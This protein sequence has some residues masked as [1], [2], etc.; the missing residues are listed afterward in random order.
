MEKQSHSPGIHLAESH[1]LRLILNCGASV[2][3][4]CV[5]ASQLR[6]ARGSASALYTTALHITLECLPVFTKQNKVALQCPVQTL[7][8]KSPGPGRSC[9]T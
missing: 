2:V 5:P 1:L 4:L 9:P 7:L 8:D 6:K 3:T